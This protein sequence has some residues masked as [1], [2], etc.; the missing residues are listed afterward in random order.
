MNA[1]QFFD[2][3]SE[4]RQKQTEFFKTHNPIVLQQ[5]KD[6]ERLVDKEIARVKRL[7]TEPELNFEQ[8]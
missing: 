7:Q 5:S 1:K 4:M 2:L 8:V 6:L 3:V